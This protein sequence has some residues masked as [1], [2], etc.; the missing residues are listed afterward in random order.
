MGHSSS[1]VRREFELNVVLKSVVNAKEE[2]QFETNLSRLQAEGAL[3][4]TTGSVY[5][6]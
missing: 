5:V 4:W 2:K 6:E 3:K 1:W